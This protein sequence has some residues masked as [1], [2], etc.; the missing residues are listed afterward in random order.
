VLALAVCAFTAAGHDSPS[1]IADWATGCG[2]EDL[3][4]VRDVTFREDAQKARTGNMPA[5]L[6]ALR[7][8]AIGA[9]RKAGFANTAHARRHY[10]CDDQRILALYGYA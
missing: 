10:V 5:N 6:A 9:F 3:P 1:A 2:Q 8:L 4:Y 7:N